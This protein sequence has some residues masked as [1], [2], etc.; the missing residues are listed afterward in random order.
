MQPR[1]YCALLALFFAA[2]D[3]A[4]TFGILTLFGIIPASMAW[5]MRYADE[6]LPPA[7]APVVPGGKGTL[8]GMIGIASAIIAFE[9]ANKFGVV[10]A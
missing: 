3:N 9:V 10:V 2:L 6:G 7:V 5:S 1:Q 8:G 4:G